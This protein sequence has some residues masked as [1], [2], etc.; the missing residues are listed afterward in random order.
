MNDLEHV[1]SAQLR[2]DV[3]DFRPGD[4]VKVHVRVVEGGRER[5]QVFE[6]VVIARDGSRLNATFT[7]R[8]ISFGGRCRAD[9]PGARPHHPEDRGDTSRSGAARQA[10]LLARSGWE[11]GSNP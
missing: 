6:G 5:V 11:V 3:P 7:V 4:T 9:L 1:Q 8:K 2:D 10:L